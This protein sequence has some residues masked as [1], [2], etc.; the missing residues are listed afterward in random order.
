MKIKEIKREKIILFL[1]SF[2]TVYLTAFLGSLFTS[3]QVN[4]EW[5]NSIKPSITPPN[6]VFPLVWNFLFFLIAI[7]FYFALLNKNKK[8]KTQVKILFLSNLFFNLAWS[9]FYFGLKNIS[10]ALID[11][12]LLI[13]S[14]VL[15]I[16]KLKGIEKKSS[17]LLFPYLIWLLFAMILNL[18]SL[19]KFLG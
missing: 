4:S 15:L 14:T 5:Y 2:F 3:S 19:I 12:I 1:F 11:I 6:F 16:L 13:F 18:L 17:F 7:S 9:F 10:L 8:I